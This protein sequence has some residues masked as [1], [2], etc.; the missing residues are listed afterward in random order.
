[1]MKPMRRLVVDS[2]ML[3]SEDLRQFLDASASN[4]AVLPDFVWFE[5]Y[6]QESIGA[7]VAGMSVIGE[8]PEQVIVLKPG[9]EIAQIDPRIPN[10]TSSMHHS[11]VAHQLRFA[12][13]MSETSRSTVAPVIG[14]AVAGSKL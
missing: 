6:K 3:Q 7:I 10:M 4:F 11:D 1:M 2:G 13:S 14:F 5:L 8:F 9:K 12:S